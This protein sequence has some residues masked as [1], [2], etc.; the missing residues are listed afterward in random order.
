MD[1][2]LWK[3]SLLGYLNITLDWIREEIPGIKIDYEKTNLVNI[4]W[5]HV[6][7][8]NGYHL[9]PSSY[10]I[11]RAVVEETYKSIIMTPILQANGYV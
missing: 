3:I 7:W 1:S 2:E 5:T 8:L 6:V 10:S 4:N 11:M 9:H